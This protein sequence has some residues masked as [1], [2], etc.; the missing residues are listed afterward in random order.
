MRLGILDGTW[1]L[2]GNGASRIQLVLLGPE[3]GGVLYSRFSESPDDH[4]PFVNPSNTKKEKRLCVVWIFP[5]SA[6]PDRGG[7]PADLMQQ[8][9]KGMMKAK[10]L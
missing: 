4:V 3:L 7:C 10:L 2:G 6:A 9:G 8:Q 1:R 5:R